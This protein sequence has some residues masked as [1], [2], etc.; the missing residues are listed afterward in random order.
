MGPA[1]GMLS[2]KKMFM[3]VLQ[4]KLISYKKKLKQIRNQYLKSILAFQPYR[5]LTCPLLSAS[6]SG[7]LSIPPMDDASL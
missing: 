5:N 7:D 3:A 6:I 4:Y 2:S 1:K